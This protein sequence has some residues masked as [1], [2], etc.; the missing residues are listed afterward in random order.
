MSRLSPPSPLSHL[1]L[2]SPCP[3]SFRSVCLCL[4]VFHSLIQSLL[5]LIYFWLILPPQRYK[6]SYLLPHCSFLSV[7]LFSPFFNSFSSEFLFFPPASF[8]SSIWHPPPTNHL[9]HLSFHHPSAP[10]HTMAVLPSGSWQ[11]TCYYNSQHALS[12]LKQRQVH[13][14]KKWA[15]CTRMESVCVSCNITRTLQGWWTHS[16]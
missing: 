10:S 6:E 15:A 14:I 8:A 4:L 9:L 7:S 1:T 11:G 2:S 13:P 12:D 5:Y 16:R 3:S